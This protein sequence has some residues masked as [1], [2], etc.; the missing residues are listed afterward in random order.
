MPTV[1]KSVIVPHAVETMFALVDACER[2]PEFL[3]WCSAVEVFER[4]ASLTR[5]RLEIDYQGLRSRFSTLNRK[6]PPARIDL[7]LVDGPFEA[8]A[9]HWSFAALGDA[10][11]RVELALDY[12][13]ANAALEALLGSVFGHVMETLVERFVERAAAQASGKVAP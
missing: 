12:A 11:C 10:G 9:G 13:F 4:S 7:E 6:R 5:A 3:P 8:L 1:R 2:Y